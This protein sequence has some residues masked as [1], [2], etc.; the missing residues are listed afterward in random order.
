MTEQEQRPHYEE[1][2]LAM[3]DAITKYENATGWRVTDL[4]L[5]AKPG[6]SRLE[7]RNE[8]PS[9]TAYPMPRQR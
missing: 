8:P 6:S 2:H 7:V 1:M 3:L 4:N 9:E 5:T